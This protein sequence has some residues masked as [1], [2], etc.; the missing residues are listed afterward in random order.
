LTV[1][2]DGKLWLSPPSESGPLLESL[3]QLLDN[4]N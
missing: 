3:P 2:I 1:H 4:I